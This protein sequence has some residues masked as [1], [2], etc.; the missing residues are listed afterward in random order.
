MRMHQRIVPSSSPSPSSPSA[1]ARPGATKCSGCSRS[2]CYYCCCCCCWSS[3]RRIAQR[4]A[5]QRSAAQRGGE[6]PVA[7]GAILLQ[8]APTADAPRR[9]VPAATMPTDSPRSRAANSRRADGAHLRR[10]PPTL[11]H[12]TLNKRAPNLLELMLI[13][14]NI[15]NRAPHH[16][17]PPSTTPLL[18]CPT[19]SF[20]RPS[21]SQ[22][23]R[24][25]GMP[26]DP[27]R[28]RE[29]MPDARMAHGVHTVELSVELSLI[30]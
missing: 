6:Y 27:L 9:D 23:I 20:R 5:A 4:S 30:P 19:I 16:T 13:T 3:A 10:Y 22:S 24:I 7:R 18:T 21:H 28:I 2:T 26:S 1:A 25:R 15:I 11:H 14:R 29:S 8:H 17:H 12:L